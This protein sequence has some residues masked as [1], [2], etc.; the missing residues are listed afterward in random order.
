MTKQRET[1][2]EE[3]GA[4]RK[5]TMQECVTKQ[6][7]TETEEQGA[8]HKKTDCDR[9]TKQRQT[10]TE[11]QGAKHKKTKRDC[12]RKKREEMRHQSQNDRRDCYWEDMTNVINRATKE[13]KQFRIRQTPICIG[14]LCVLYA[15]VSLLAQKPFTN[16]PRKTLV[17]TV[18]D[19][20]SKVTKS[21]TK[22]H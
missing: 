8:K 20:V 21:T 11:E 14:Q 4:K 15:I 17:H 1:E 22:P 16:L 5:K 13:A 7:Q 6:Q 2:T 19:L 18:E 9:K 3:Q 10:E 12:M